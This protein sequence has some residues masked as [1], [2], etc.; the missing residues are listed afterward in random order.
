[1]KRMLE[2]PNAFGDRYSN[3]EFV[4]G[5]QA[6]SEYT[7]YNHALTGER[8][9]LTGNCAG[10]LDP[11]FS[12]GVAFATESGLCA[13]KLLDRQLRGE[14]ID[15][16]REYEDH[17]RFGAEVFRSYVDTWY[18][19]D[20]QEVFFADDVQQSYKERIVSVLAGYVWDLSNP[21]VT[22]HTKAVRSLA[23]TIRL[24]QAERKARTGTGLH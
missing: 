8:Y 17:I 22:K 2:I 18:N 16:K 6:I 1:M 15:W 14:A 5:P 19:G 12:S 24:S 3:V 9:V 10:F 21:F 23:E 20:L 11:V 7:H 4:H 13:A